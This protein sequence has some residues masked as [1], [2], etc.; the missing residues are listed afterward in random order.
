MT[1]VN[2]DLLLDVTQGLD[3]ESAILMMVLGFI[4]QFTRE[5]SMEFAVEMNRLTKIEM[6]GSIG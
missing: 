3:E 5:V 4:E 1:L 6:E 2:E